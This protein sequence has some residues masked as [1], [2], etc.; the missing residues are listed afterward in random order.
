MP[1]IPA[2]P[3]RNTGL[4]HACTRGRQYKAQKENGHV[5]GLQDQRYRSVTRV[6]HD[7]ARGLA[8][9]VAKFSNGAAARPGPPAHPPPI[10]Q[11]GLGY[12][13]DG[14]SDRPP[15]ALARPTCGKAEAGH[16][17]RGEGGRAVHQHRRPRQTCGG[18]QHVQGR[19]V[20]GAPHRPC[21]RPSHC[22]W[23]AGVRMGRRGGPCR[24]GPVAK[25]RQCATGRWAQ[26]GPG[27]SRGLGPGLCLVIRGGGGGIDLLGVVGHLLGVVAHPPHPRTPH[28]PPPPGGGGGQQGSVHCQHCP[29]P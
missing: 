26:A 29:L 17:A 9:E 20:R 14:G 2:S 16:A 11:R 28:I 8:T 13:P 18:P 4:V 24:D 25:E 27:A 21:P 23:G 5:S 10:P 3:R 19:R 15:R 6:R 7:D 1:L 22:T 12:P